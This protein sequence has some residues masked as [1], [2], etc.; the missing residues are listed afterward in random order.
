MLQQGLS[1]EHRFGGQ[2]LSQHL[3]GGLETR[4]YH[5]RNRLRAPVLVLGTEPRGPAEPRSG[6]RA[7]S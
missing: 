4:A 2:R 6:Q 1:S 7:S 3:A 5:Q